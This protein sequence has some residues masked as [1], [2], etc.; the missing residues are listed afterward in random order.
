[1]IVICP[2]VTESQETSGSERAHQQG[3][4]GKKGAAAASAAGSGSGGGRKGKG[5]GGGASE[6]AAAHEV[7][8]QQG[9][10]AAAHERQQKQ[11]AVTPQE[12]S[13]R[14]KDAFDFTQG[15]Q[16]TCPSGR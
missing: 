14:A 16:A 7:K 5:K 13:G 4:A 9:K 15:R 2:V 12:V 6:M 1:M 3:G 8:Q 11:P 10:Q